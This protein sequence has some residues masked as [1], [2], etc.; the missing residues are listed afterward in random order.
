MMT[1]LQL[2]E[3]D[4]DIKLTLDKLKLAMEEKIEEQKPAQQKTEQ[5]PEDS[6]K[7]KIRKAIREKM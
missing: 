7:E 4:Q 2:K 6:E 1:E 3:K 5:K